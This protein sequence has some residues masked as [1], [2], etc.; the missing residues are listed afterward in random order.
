LQEGDKGDFHMKNE[1]TCKYCGS[2]LGYIGEL[3]LIHHFS[4]E[5]CDLIFEQKETCK[6][7]MRKQS[8]PESY[9]NNFYKPTKALLE[10]NTVE[11]FHLLRDCRQE[12]Y[13][14]YNLLGRMMNLNKDELELNPNIDEAFKPLYSEY[15]QL[16]KQKFII[17]NILLEKAGFLPDKITEEFLSQLID[18]GKAASE[19]PMYIYIKKRK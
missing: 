13:N 14:I 10:C 1:E 6:N 15:I 11:L 5:Y 8:V 2:V 18:Q 3:D 12:W 4:C 16:T 9:D 7:R 19:K 17:E